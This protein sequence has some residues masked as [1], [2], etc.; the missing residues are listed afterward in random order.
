V[1][2]RYAGE[3]TACSCKSELGSTPARCAEGLTTINDQIFCHHEVHAREYL[4]TCG[5]GLPYHQRHR[6]PCDRQQRRRGPQPHR[7]PPCQCGPRR[8]GWASLSVV[9]STMPRLS[10]TAED[11]VLRSGSRRPVIVATSHSQGCNP[12]AARRCW[13]AAFHLKRGVQ[14]C[15]KIAA[16]AP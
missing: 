1:V 16:P 12:W 4:A 6:R 14:E 15:P 7:R 9:N 13:K 2:K 3:A 11:E 5:L 10:A 8:T